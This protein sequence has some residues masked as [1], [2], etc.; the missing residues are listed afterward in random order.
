MTLQEI[1]DAYPTFQ[2]LFKEM[3]VYIQEKDGTHRLVFDTRFEF[4]LDGDM[5]LIIQLYPKD[6]E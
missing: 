4:G 5:G 3:E 1:I 6:E 2:P